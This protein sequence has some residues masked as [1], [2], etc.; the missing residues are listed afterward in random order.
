MI[1]PRTFLFI[2]VVLFSLGVW[3]AHAYALTGIE[4]G[5][6]KVEYIGQRVFAIESEMELPMS[7]E[8]NHMKWRQPSHKAIK[9][10]DKTRR[11]LAELILAPEAAGLRLK[12]EGVI[13]ALKRIYDGIER[14]SAQQ[15]EKEFINFWNANDRYGGLLKDKFNAH[16][17]LNLSKDFDIKNEELKLFKNGIDRALYEKSRIL[18]REKKFKE[19]NSILQELL[20]SYEG[21]ILEG[22]IASLII[23]CF[24]NTQSDLEGRGDWAYSLGLMTK[25]LNNG[26]YNLA[27]YALF[28]KWR[29]VYQKDYYGMSSM[30]EIPNDEYNQKRWNVV[31]VI[32]KYLEKNP[33]DMWA[34]AQIVLLM[35]IPIIERGSP[36]SPM[37]NTNLFH[38]VN[39]F[40]HANCGTPTNPN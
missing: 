15:I 21:H 31:R 22:S 8:A 28:T 4:K 1:L 39:L 16:F 6:L 10:L 35:G 33:G 29:T 7:S 13:D 30:A 9:D 23:D 38:C 3:P 19:A 36:D 27:L 11:G 14:K 34:R 40:G 26:K 25:I 2:F 37:S 24:E 17:R 20:K 5:I 12:L 32:Q 18:I